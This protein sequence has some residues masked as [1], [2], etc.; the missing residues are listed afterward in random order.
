MQRV[1]LRP[2][3]LKLMQW[4]VSCASFDT[5]QSDEFRRATYW[6]GLNGVMSAPVA[7]SVKGQ[8]ANTMTFGL[9]NTLWGS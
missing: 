4:Q 1:H 6:A 5:A 8:A 9:Y 3:M 7:M 2:D